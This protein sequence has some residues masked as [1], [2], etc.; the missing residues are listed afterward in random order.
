MNATI[1][2]LTAAASR[3]LIAQFRLSTRNDAAATSKP[4][5]YDEE[6]AM[7]NAVKNLINALQ[8]RSGAR[9]PLIAALFN[10]VNQ[11]AAAAALGV[12]RS[13]IQ[14]AFADSRDGDTA[15]SNCNA[16]RRSIR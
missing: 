12:S 13:T 4:K 6:I 11:Q 5:S 14:R 10:G 7:S 15:I 16:R 9:R 1:F 3:L 8:L 2:L